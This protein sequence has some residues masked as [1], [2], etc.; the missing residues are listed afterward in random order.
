MLVLQHHK[1]LRYAMQQHD[2]EGWWC[3]FDEEMPGGHIIWDPATHSLVKRV[4]VNG[5]PTTL[6]QDLMGPLCEMRARMLRASRGNTEAD[7]RNVME[8][9]R[10]SE[11]LQREHRAAHRDVLR[12]SKQGTD[13]FEKAMSTGKLLDE[14]ALDLLTRYESLEKEI[15]ARRKAE[16]GHGLQPTGGAPNGQAGLEV[17]PTGGVPNELA[18]GVEIL[19]AGGVAENN[20]GRAKR[21]RKPP[22]DTTSWKSSAWD[23]MNASFNNVDT[24]EE[25]ETAWS[26]LSERQKMFDHTEVH[27]H[28]GGCGVYD[29]SILHT[30]TCTC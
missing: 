20:G 18:G 29:K 1:A 17:Q 4:Q 15:A 11:L 24:F 10:R 22:A 13:A 7:Y 21:N 2:G 9:I 28:A 6:Y 14:S 16:A 30:S 12:Q 5:D 19:K 27:T 3:G 25:S 23:S 8:A 26:K